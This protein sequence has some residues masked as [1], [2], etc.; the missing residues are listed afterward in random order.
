MLLRDLGEVGA[1]QTKRGSPVTHAPSVH[2]EHVGG[3][4]T[5]IFTDLRQGPYLYCHGE[6]VFICAC[7]CAPQALVAV[8]SLKTVIPTLPG[9]VH[10]WLGRWVPDKPV[11]WLSL[12]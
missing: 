9:R 8:V 2:S 10:T 11:P 5:A 1:G 3:H 6:I 12:G 7:A 4:F